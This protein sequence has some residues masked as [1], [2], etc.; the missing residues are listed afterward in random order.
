MN[1]SSSNKL[2]VTASPNVELMLVAA[3]LAA[4][5]LDPG[6]YGTLNHRIAQAARS[7]FAP[8]ADHP[9]VAAV[10]NLFYL[11]NETWSGFACD[12]V[13]SFILRRGE[14]PEFKARYPYSAS[15]LARANGDSG[16]L[17]HLLEQLRDFYWTSYFSSFWEKHAGAYQEIENQI[18]GCVESGWAGEDVID[19]MESYFGEQRRSYT[20]VPTPMERPAGGTMD[21][22]GDGNHNIVACF[23]CTVNKEWILHLLYH[24]A[25]HGFV[26]P[27]AERYGALVEQYEELYASLEECMHPWGYTSWTIALNEHILRAQNCRLWRRFYGDVI[28][29]AQLEREEA[30]G[31]LYIRA[32]ENKLAEYESR[33]D[34][35]PSLAD[36]Y[37]QLIAVLDPF[38]R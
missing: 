13:T 5:G 6:H 30:Q 4:P 19:T 21:A 23:D 12:A 10:R 16:V 25:G 17:D 15:A 27:L 33:R 1:S 34:S 14:P 32:F 36:F 11:K 31:F 20:L 38:M 26:N 2:T 8:Y 24:E 35:Y 22:M 29:E 37:P 28:A 18:A 9:A 3:M 7:W